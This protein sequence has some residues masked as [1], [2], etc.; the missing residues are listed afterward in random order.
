ML[1]YVH[2]IVA[3][4]VST[5]FILLK[6]QWWQIFL[7]FLAA[8]FIDVDHYFYYIA[9]KKSWNLIKAYNY[10]CNLNKLLKKK[11][12]G[13][14]ILIIFHTVEAFLLI[15]ILTFPFFN[16]FFPLLLGLIIHYIL[17]IISLSLNRAKRYKRAYSII[18]YLMRK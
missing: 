16:I 1:P 6:W 12:K 8:V 17:D 2:F 10:F 5:I 15:L 3:L 13:T 11:Q 9:N 18:Y 4:L 14:K 7:F